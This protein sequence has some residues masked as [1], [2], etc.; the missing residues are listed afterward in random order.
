MTTVLHPSTQVHA[1]LLKLPGQFDSLRMKDD[2]IA[3]GV[4]AVFGIKGMDAELV[5]LFFQAG[6]YSPVEAEQWLRERRL[7]VIQFTRA[8]EN[9]A[10]IELIPA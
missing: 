10:H 4:T 5:A 7:S 3:E 1:A 9:Q 2:L 8:G 6:Q